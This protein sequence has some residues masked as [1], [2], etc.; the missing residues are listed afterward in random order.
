MIKSND[1]YHMM[2]RHYKEQGGI[3]ED[4]WLNLYQSFYT[5]QIDSAP[6]NIHPGLRSQKLFADFLTEE[7]KKHN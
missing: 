6:N 2:H 1:L 7:F 5:M 3:R 4:H